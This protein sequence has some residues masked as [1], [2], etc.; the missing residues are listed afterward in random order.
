MTGT[1][2]ALGVALVLV[3]SAYVGFASSDSEGLS[4]GGVDITPVSGSDIDRDAPP[5]ATPTAV[6]EATAEPTAPV[7]NRQDCNQIRGTQYLSPE[8]R[9]WYLDN[10]VRN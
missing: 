9:T 6:P 4:A 8:E 7:T 2:A 10:C 1:L 3:A 5:E